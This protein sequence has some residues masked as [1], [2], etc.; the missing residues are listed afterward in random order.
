MCSEESV[1]L[2]D[3]QTQFASLFGALE[4]SSCSADSGLVPIK[5]TDD[6]VPIIRS[7]SDAAWVILN[8]L[9]EALDPAL[10]KALES[11]V[12]IKIRLPR[13]MKGCPSLTS[14]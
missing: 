7:L 14:E 1:F 5:Q 11:H 2:Y 12:Q 3:H 9:I 8:V 6:R 10:N 4:I 13:V